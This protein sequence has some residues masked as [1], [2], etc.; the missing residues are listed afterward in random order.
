MEHVRAVHRK[1]HLKIRGQMGFIFRL[2]LMINGALYLFP[3][4]LCP[5][6]SAMKLFDPVAF[7]LTIQTLFPAFVED[8]VLARMAAYG[9][10]VFGLA[11]LAAGLA[12][13]YG[14][15]RSVDAA[16]IATY[17]VE[18]LM[19]VL[20]TE[21]FM[22]SRPTD[23]LTAVIV[24]NMLTIA[25]IFV[26]TRFPYPTDEKYSKL[27]MKSENANPILRY[28]LIINGLLVDML[29]LGLIPLYQTMN[30]GPALPFSLPLTVQDIWPSFVVGRLQE[31]MVM[32]AFLGC[33]CCRLTAGL[34]KF[35]G[36]VRVVDVVA[37]LSYGAE[38][39]MVTS[40]AMFFESTKFE[41]VIP[42]IGI[43]SLCIASLFLG[44]FQGYTC[45][46]LNA[47]K[48]KAD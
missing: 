19:V 39:L 13:F 44:Q 41:A 10:V 3:M 8:G 11:R 47:A 2:W 31:R 9:F 6:L 18:L 4:G 29:F 46:G 22:T 14:A 12:P 42:A 20:E 16:A 25:G 43:T 27:D 7:P 23:P 48:P 34:G 24:L 5:L 32:Y 1:E 15:S 38:L 30:I 45:D 28:W 40:E 37:M 33:G 36:N 21:V 17:G 26:G 35:Y